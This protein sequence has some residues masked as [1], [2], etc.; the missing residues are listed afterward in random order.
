MA[1]S[2]LN[3]P[4]I[5]VS[6]ATVQVAPDATDFNRRRA[7]IYI[8]NYSEVNPMYIHFTP[9]PTLTDVGIKLNPGEALIDEQLASLEMYQGA[10]YCYCL[11]G[12]AVVVETFYI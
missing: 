9:S 3:Y 11:S 7:G 8:R 2:R 5:A 4:I 1:V 12:Y 10:Y 6:G